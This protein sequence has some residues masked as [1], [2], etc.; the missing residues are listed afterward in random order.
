MKNLIYIILGA[1]IGALLTYYFCPRPLEDDG[2]IK[3][4]KPKGVITV[5]KAKEL[6]ENW[7]LYR[8]AAVDSAAQKQ[9][10]EQDD[11]S[12]YWD[13]DE[14]EN[15]L[16]FAKNQSDSLGYQMTGI[17][18]Y[19]GVYGKNAG[20]TKKDLTTMFIVPTGRKSKASSLNLN[21]R[22]NDEDVPGGNPL[23][24]GAGGQGGYPN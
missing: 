4:V 17:R 7:T 23:N 22:G 12:T 24:D 20:Q 11:R 10:R 16:A 19:L 21:F 9:G 3:I 1:I 8:K 14:I 5:D 2:P 6:N 13:L 15:Y 18:V